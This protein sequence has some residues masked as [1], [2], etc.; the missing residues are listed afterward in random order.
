M[1][2]IKTYKALKDTNI[3]QVMCNRYMIDSDERMEN[4]TFVDDRENSFAFHDRELKLYGV[5][6][7]EKHIGYNLRN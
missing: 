2:S 6:W 4:V 7:L 3:N 1:W 5:K